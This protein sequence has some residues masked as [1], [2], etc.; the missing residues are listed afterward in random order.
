MVRGSLAISGP[1]VQEGLQHGMAMFAFDGFGVELYA[2][3][4]E[5]AVK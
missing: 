3:N 2:L 4:A 5:L 1:A